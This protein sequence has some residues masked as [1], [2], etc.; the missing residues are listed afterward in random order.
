MYQLH[1]RNASIMFCKH[2]LI[3]IKKKLMNT[4]KEL[5]NFEINETIDFIYKKSENIREKVF[6]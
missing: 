1:T 2:G 3:K 5:T 4:S 6:H